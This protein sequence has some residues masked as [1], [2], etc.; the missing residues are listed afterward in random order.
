MSNI[1]NRERMTSYSRLLPSPIHGDTST[2]TR[3]RD[4]KAPRKTREKKKGKETRVNTK[5]HILTEAS[6]RLG[7]GVDGGA[8]RLARLAEGG[9]ANGDGG[10]E[11]ESRH[12]WCCVCACVCV[13]VCVW[14]RVVIVR[15]G[16]F[17][18]LLS[19]PF[20]VSRLELYPRVVATFCGSQAL[21]SV[22]SPL[23]KKVP[24]RDGKTHRQ[25]RSR[26]VSLYPTRRATPCTRTKTNHS[27]TDDKR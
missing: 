22:L 3:T 5:S 27:H 23:A 24:M 18:C 10:G 16:V 13:R 21:L 4:T 25:L 11:G 12:V 17:F 14:W 19:P 9:G 6:E 26:L 2:A 1:N 20:D 15:Q 8:G 7:G